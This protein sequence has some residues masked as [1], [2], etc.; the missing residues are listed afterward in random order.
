VTT[1][2]DISKARHDGILRAVVTLYPEKERLVGYIIC[3]TTMEAFDA[4]DAPLGTFPDR[5]DALDTILVAY[6]ER[7]AD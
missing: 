2:Y 3:T 4:D 6:L 1:T 5:H 7:G